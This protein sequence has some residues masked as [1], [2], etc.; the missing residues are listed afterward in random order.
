M[1]D[2]IIFDCDGVLIDSEWLVNQIEIEELARLGYPIPME[3]YLD[4]SLGRTHEE[5]EKQLFKRFG[6]RPHYKFWKAVRE[7]Q[8]EEFEEKLTP[9]DGVLEG[10]QNL[11]VPYCVASNSDSERLKLTLNITGIFPFLDGRIFGCECVKKG[12]PEPDIF[13]YAAHKMGIKPAKCLV[14]EDSVHGIKA[15][16]TA[17]MEVWGFCGGRH[18]TPKRKESLS[19]AGV[20][21][22][23]DD[24]TKVLEKVG[25]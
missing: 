10:I 17:G 5:V 7:R 9:I 18:F 25:K 20:R 1:F 16:Q 24:M 21:H 4:I 19:K 15:A 13:L 14:I 11:S 22:I 8:A 12:K 3:D 23:F 2:L 6:F